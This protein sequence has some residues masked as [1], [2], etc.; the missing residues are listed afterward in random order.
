MSSPR[1]DRDHL[2]SARVVMKIPSTV[3][4]IFTIALFCSRH[5]LGFS[6]MSLLSPPS[7]E[8]SNRNGCDFGRH[9]EMQILSITHLV[10]LTSSSRQ[11]GFKCISSQ[12]FF[13]KS[14]AQLLTKYSKLSRQCRGLMSQNMRLDLLL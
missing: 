10:S 5:D 11:V 12:G 9:C 8:Q 1:L 13:L 3:S 4:K 6:N 2:S 7:P 14:P